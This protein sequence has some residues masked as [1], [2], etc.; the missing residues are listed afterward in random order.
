MPDD[1]DDEEDSVKIIR[2][3]KNR[4]PLVRLLSILCSDMN[5]YSGEANL[6]ACVPFIPIFK[7]CFLCVFR[8]LM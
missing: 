3:V 6:N 5:K 4:E 2:L 8:L 1:I 7:I